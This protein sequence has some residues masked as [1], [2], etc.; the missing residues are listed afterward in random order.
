MPR[1]HFNVYDGRQII[2][3]VGTDFDTFGEARK[4]AF[5]VAGR[6]ILEQFEHVSKCD[7]W[8]LEITDGDG[9]VLIWLEL[10]MT[11]SPALLSLYRAER[12]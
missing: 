3:R 11:E 7:E 1:F 6:I 4:E 9:L 5:A 8:R 2:D 10:N 12:R